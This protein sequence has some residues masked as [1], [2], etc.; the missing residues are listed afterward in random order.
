MAL[1]QHSAYVGIR[2]TNRR[3]THSLRIDRS[4]IAFSSR[5]LETIAVPHDR[6]TGVLSAVI[7][8]STQA[9]C[10]HDYM[11]I[12]C[13]ISIEPPAFRIGQPLALL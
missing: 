4:A 12:A 6:M 8:A 13:A 2:A 9:E 10:H 1:E 3:R 5:R 7:G 11:S